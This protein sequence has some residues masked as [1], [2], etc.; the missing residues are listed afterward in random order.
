MLAAIRRAGITCVIPSLFPS[1]PVC[2]SWAGVAG[3][4]ISVGENMDHAWVG[5]SESFAG[6]WGGCTALVR[7][8]D[9]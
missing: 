7:D 2:T 3:E 9:Y 6:S 4:M 5:R 8:L 1:A